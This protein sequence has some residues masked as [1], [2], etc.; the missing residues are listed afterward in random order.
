L[1]Q[2]CPQRVQFCGLPS[3]VAQPAF[4]LVLQFA[5]PGSHAASMQEASTH[6]ALACK[7]LHASPQP[8]QC[9]ASLDRLV[10]Q[11]SPLTVSL[12]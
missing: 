7:K 2:I 8:P 9:S 5:Q 12:S 6:A 1:L 4:G 11:P 10:S 3:R